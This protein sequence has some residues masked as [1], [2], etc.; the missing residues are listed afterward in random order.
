M[1]THYMYKNSF[2][3][4]NMKWK[5]LGLNLRTPELRPLTQVTE[6]SASL[7]E[8]MQ[9]IVLRGGWVEPDITWPRLC[10]TQV[11]FPMFCTIHSAHRYPGP[12]TNWETLVATLFIKLVFKEEHIETPVDGGAGSAWTER[13]CSGL[14]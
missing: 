14:S 9:D 6:A 12:F 1:F 13:K 7:F 8:L 3:E 10:C 4:L 2:K 11:M 5:S